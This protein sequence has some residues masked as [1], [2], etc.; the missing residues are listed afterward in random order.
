MRDEPYVSPYAG[1]DLAS[2][3][4]KR[5]E[6]H[7]GRNFLTWAPFEGAAKSWTYA[8]FADDA[9]RLADGLARRGVRPGD[10]VMINLENAPEYLLAWHALA[11]IGAVAVATNARAS[12]EE[13]AYFADHAGVAAAITQPALAARVRDFCTG[14]DWLAVTAHDGGVEPRD[15]D[16]P[17]GD[18]RFEAL[19]GDA[20]KA[21]APA[22]DGR[23]PLAVHYTSGSTARPK[24]V[25]WTHDNVL[26]GGQ[27]S[28]NHE[29]L[30]EADRHLVTLPLFHVVSGIYSTMASLWA[31]A[32][33][34]LQPRF[35]ARN[36]W[37]AAV[38]H[39]C[40]WASLVPFCSEALR[41][42]PV[43]E[44]HWFRNW[45]HAVLD[46]SVEA[47]FRVPL[48]GWWG[49]TEIITQ[50][51]VGDPGLPKRDG[52]IGRPAPEYRLAVL[53][54]DGSPVE[55]G[56]TGELRI[57]GTPG[58]SL[59]REYLDNPAATA[60][61]FDERGYFITGDLVTLHEDGLIGFADRAKDMLKV[62][63]ENVSPAE[64]ERVIG[65]I[66]GVA[67]VAVVGKTDA[68]RDEVP[69]AFVVPEG[70]SE[71]GSE[72]APDLA[73]LTSAIE[74]R[75]MAALADF[76]QPR[77]IRFLD[78]L[79]RTGGIAKVSKPELRRVIEAESG[80]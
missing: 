63:G 37:P 49:M 15:A 10:R 71:A 50:G 5:A 8:A 73:A 26:W 31:G 13:L 58:L 6:S 62:G 47:H 59:F 2:L 14:L 53:R 46:S 60:E 74:Q 34:V 68:L 19:F 64:L 80:G 78:D 12:G 55:P 20:A 57:L 30:T 23:R 24:G 41:R 56:E 27:V 16:R 77:E 33:V 45:G 44:R 9:A 17:S 7:G 66:D 29:R 79:P 72:D 28:A 54:D 25:V 51:I 42:E 69:V 3:L 11:R 67:E 36:F 65:Q 32:E 39:R 40:T 43:P 76:K 4:L 18:E 22:G 1:L 21:P 75:C 70:L 35:S 48:L 38:A 61:S 52:A